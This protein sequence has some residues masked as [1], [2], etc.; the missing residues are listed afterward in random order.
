[1]L[2]VRLRNLIVINLYH[3]QIIYLDSTFI[4]RRMVFPNMF[5]RVLPLLLRLLLRRSIFFLWPI[6]STWFPTSGALCRQFF[7][8]VSTI[9]NLGRDFWRFNGVTF[10][11]DFCENC[12]LGIYLYLLRNPLGYLIIVRTLNGTSGFQ[13]SGRVYIQGPPLRLSTIR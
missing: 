12:M 4:S 10:I 13:S 11:R 1:M 2:Q 9:S 7:G 6:S 3:P 5:L 8:I